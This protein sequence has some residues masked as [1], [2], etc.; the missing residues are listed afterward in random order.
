LREVREGRFSLK[1]YIGGNG[2]IMAVEGKLLKRVGL[3]KLWQE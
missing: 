3:G 2:E 1:S